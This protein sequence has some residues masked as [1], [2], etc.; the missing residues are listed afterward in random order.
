MIT[1]E[2]IHDL[3]NRLWEA[4]YT[5]PDVHPHIVTGECPGDTVAVE[6]IPESTEG[7]PWVA[8]FGLTTNDQGCVDG[9]QGTAYDGWD[10]DASSPQ[11]WASECGVYLG[12]LPAQDSA[13]HFAGG[14]FGRYMSDA[15]GGLF[16][17]EAVAE[18]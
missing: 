2:N 10:P 11:W 13:G 14:D 4:F 1:I 5:E 8:F 7:K 12:W 18:D 17:P 3:E 15:F 16:H 9:I 6:V